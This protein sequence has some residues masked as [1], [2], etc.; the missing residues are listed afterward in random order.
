MLACNLAGR[1]KAHRDGFLNESKGPHLRLSNDQ[2][3]HQHGQPRRRSIQ[4]P[5][6]VLI[7]TNICYGHEQT[8]EWPAL[9]NLEEAK[10]CQAASKNMLPMA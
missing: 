7:P 3:L 1:P 4:E 5:A 8:K 10:D 9:H 2:E 6:G